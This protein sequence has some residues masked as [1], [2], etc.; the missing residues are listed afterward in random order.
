M[1]NFTKIVSLFVLLT[2]IVSC[3]VGCSGS[4]SSNQTN[5]NSN[6]TIGNGETESNNTSKEDFP[7]VASDI[8]QADLKSLDGKTFKLQ[9]LKGKTVLINFWATWCGPCRAE[10]PE[11]VKLQEKYKDKGFEVIGVN[12]DPEDTPAAIK[13]FGEKMNLNYKLAQSEL[14]FFDQFLKL[15]KFD[16]IPQSFL[17][18]GE[19]KLRGMF[20]GGGPKTI[21]KVKD[22]VAKLLGDN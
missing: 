16:G 8:M 21:E 15:S 7:A 14:S 6:E 9:D 4:N 5:V 18:D 3:F 22:N 19:G 12:S 17:I 10:M 1:K 13:A 2:I 11:L 20:L